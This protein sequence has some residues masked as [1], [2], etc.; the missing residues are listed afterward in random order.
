MKHDVVFSLKTKKKHENLLSVPSS[1]SDSFVFYTKQF[2]LTNQ[3]VVR[4]NTMD[5]KGSFN[6]KELPFLSRLSPFTIRR[7]AVDR[8][9]LCN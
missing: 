1:A 2:I 8:A 3:L 7:T 6:C 4:K 9:W 5:L